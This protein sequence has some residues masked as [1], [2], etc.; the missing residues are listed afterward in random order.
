MT[1]NNGGFGD[2]D[3]LTDALSTQKFITETY[4]TWSNECEHPEVRDDLMCILSEEHQIQFDLF[5]E[6]KQRGWYQVEPADQVK[7]QQTKQ[8]FQNQQ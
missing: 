2:K 1:M 4:N 6:M 3:M 7:V 8:K 5:N